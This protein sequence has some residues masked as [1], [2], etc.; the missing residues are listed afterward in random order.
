MVKELDLFW[1]IYF[2]VFNLDMDGV[3]GQKERGKLCGSR[4]RAVEFHRVETSP[5]SQLGVELARAA[6]LLEC[7]IIEYPRKHCNRKVSL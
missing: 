4:C 2:A 6:V 5:N 1:W 3:R 7:D